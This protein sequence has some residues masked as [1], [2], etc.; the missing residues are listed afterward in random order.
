MPEYQIEMLFLCSA[1]DHNDNRGLEK[2]CV[3]CGKQ[4]KMKMI[5][6]NLSSVMTD[7]GVMCPN[8][9]LNDT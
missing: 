2:H 4:H 6:S 7:G 8:W 5:D 9:F 3:N 1:F